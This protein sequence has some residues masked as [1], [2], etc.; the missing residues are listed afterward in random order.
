MIKKAFLNRLSRKSK[1]EAHPG[2]VS[3]RNAQSIGVI[4]LYEKTERSWNTVAQLES[5][6]KNVRVINF[7]SKPEKG[8]EYPQHTFSSKDI[9]LTGSILNEEVDYFRRQSFDFLISLDTTG[10]KFIRYLVS[11]TKANHKIG[12][13]DKSLEGVMDMMVMPTNQ[14]PLEELLRYTRMIRHD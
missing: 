12:V 1:S 4:G 13:Y 6:G 9:S 14:N 8:K 10:N 2:P 5:E 7:I 3:Y 11:I